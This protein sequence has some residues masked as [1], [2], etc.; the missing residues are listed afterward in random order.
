[1]PLF[2]VKTREKYVHVTRYAVHAATAEAAVQMVKDQRISG[3]DAT[4]IDGYAP[5]DEFLG[6]LEV[7]DEHG[8]RVTLAGPGAAVNTDTGTGPDAIS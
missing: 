4:E 8:R 5:E 6:V 3:Y 2:H 7:T 1:M